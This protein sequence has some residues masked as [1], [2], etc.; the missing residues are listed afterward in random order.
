MHQNKT[1]RGLAGG[2]AL[3]A[4][5]GS[6]QHPVQLPTNLEAFSGPDVACDPNIIYFEKDV[7]P[8]LITSCAYSGCHDAETAEEDVILD[9]YANTLRTGG[10]TPGAPNRSELYTVL[11]PSSDELMPPPPEAPLSEAQIQIIYDWIKQGALDLTCN[12]CDSTVFTYTESIMPLVETY[13]QRCHSGATPDGNVSL[14]NYAEVKASVDDGSFWGSIVGEA[15]FVAM[16]P[17]STLP[18]CELSQIEQ[19]LAEGAPNN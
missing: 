4:G 17:G 15:G 14:T 7:L 10:V 11:L 8:L 16:P 5:L 1:L 18:P 2:L 9:N 12:Y 3:L 19:W 6:C 13:C